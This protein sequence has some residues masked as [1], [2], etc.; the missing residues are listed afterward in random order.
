MKSYL[1]TS[2]LILVFNLSFSQ[3]AKSVKTFLDSTWN[4]TTEANHKYYRIISDYYVI[5]NEYHV[6]DYYKSGVLQMSGTTKDKDYL[7]KNGRFLYYY[8]NGNSQSL[9]TFENDIPTGKKL[10][11]YEN[12]SKKLEGE[13]IVL[14][15]KELPIL[16]TNQ[17][18]DANGVQKVVDGNGELE[19]KT[20]NFWETGKLVNGLRQGIWKGTDKLNKISFEENYNKDKLIA[21]VSTDSLN[22]K[23]KYKIANTDARPKTDMDDFYDYISK[24]FI[25]P[26]DFKINKGNIY[27][28]FYINKEGKIS[29]IKT[30]KSLIE[31]LDNEAIRVLNSYE[32]WI[33]ATERG[34][35][36]RSAAIIL[37]FTLKD[38]EIEIINMPFPIDE[39]LV[40]RISK[41]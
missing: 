30:I 36:T 3:T 25:I 8:E 34:Q 2:L 12:G 33:P 6:R 29:E 23:H 5:K 15:K 40:R 9:V 28:Q 26:K 11:W 10:E 24:R 14:S 13:F 21:G 22:S 39:R 19:I 1:F 38:S 4:E 31:P 16:K 27:L 35:N 41:N 17:F 18:W 20:E 37:P 7:K 32:N